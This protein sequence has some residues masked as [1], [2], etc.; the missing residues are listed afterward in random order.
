MDQSQYQDFSSVTPWERFAAQL[1]Q[2]FRQWRAAGEDRLTTGEHQ[3]Q[4]LQAQSPERLAQ[5]QV[6][7]RLQHQ[8]PFRTEPYTVTLHQPSGCANAR[9]QT[10]ASDSG[11]PAMCETAHRLQQWLGVAS[12]VMLAPAS[13][14]GRIMNEQEASTLFEA[15]SIHQSTLPPKL[16]QVEGQLS[17]CAAQLQPHDPAAAAACSA[18]AAAGRLTSSLQQEASGVLLTVRQCLRVP[19]PARSTGADQGADEDDE[20]MDDSSQQGDADWDEHCPWRPWAIHNDPIGP[21]ELDLVWQRLPASAVAADPQLNPLDAH[22]WRLHP[23][24]PSQPDEG[25]GFFQVQHRSRQPLTLAPALQP[26]Q[27]PSRD[28]CTFAFMLH[29]MVACLDHAAAARTMGQL[30][31]ADWWEEHRGIPPEIPQDDTMQ[32]I[33]RDI[34]CAPR[35]P[36]LFGTRATDLEGASE[37]AA[38][39]P[40]VAAAFPASVKLLKG[41]RQGLSRTAPVHSLA[42]RVALHTMTFGNARSGSVLWRRF[43]REVRFSHWEAGLPLPC[44]QESRDAGS[45]PPNPDLSQGLLHQKLQML[46]VCIA[47]RVKAR[48]RMSE[49]QAMPSQPHVG[50]D[51]DGWEWG[52]DSVGSFARSEDADSSAQGRERKGVADFAGDMCLMSHPGK[53]M[54]VPLTQQPPGMTEDLLQERA[55]AMEAL[56]DGDSGRAARARLQG[57]VLLSDMAAFKAANPGAV[58]VD[59]VR[60]HSP[61]DWLPD[62]QDPSG[63]HMSPRMAAQ[64]GLWRQLWSEAQPCPAAEQRPL[65]DS[66]MEGERVLDWLESLGPEAVWQQL[67]AVAYSCASALLARSDGALVPAAA[68]RLSRCQ[69]QASAQIRDLPFAEWDWEGLIDSLRAAETVVVAAQSL[70]QRLPGQPLLASRLLDHACKPLLCGEDTLSEQESARDT[71]GICQGRLG[72]PLTSPSDRQHCLDL[73]QSDSQTPRAHGRHSEVEWN[74]SVYESLLLLLKEDVENLGSAGSL[75][76]ATPGF[77]RNYLVPQKQATYPTAAQKKQH[78]PKRDAKIRTTQ[79]EPT[80]HHAEID[81]AHEQNQLRLALQT[82]ADNP[83]SIRRQ[84][85]EGKLQHP[86]RA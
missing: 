34:F 85:T 25:F 20:F 16:L 3:E 84:A 37:Q 86:L 72:V 75:V 58:L 19:L 27:P 24:S 7:E 82:L 76:E 49:A 65:L 81:R 36:D 9:Q 74:E 80:A 28:G 18:A 73:L 71:C 45:S 4:G 30:C 78:K 8:L 70:I 22:H 62:P 21:L 31:S 17:L 29:N 35:L 60:W 57:D 69:Q 46:D 83:L 55:A 26:E 14:T 66:E 77:A 6:E 33:L 59:F 38:S 43:V 40:A 1:E 44:M 32:R 2:T 56:G 52:E 61:K 53:R 63:G 23:L 79:P 10:D 68:Q 11:P 13:Y 12:F 42:A 41:C 47:H 50:H 15:D 67:C 64:D 5:R 39:D 48:S 51:Q 54:C